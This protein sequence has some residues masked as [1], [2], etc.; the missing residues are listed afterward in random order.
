MGE[1]EHHLKLNLPAGAKS[2]VELVKFNDSNNTKALVAFLCLSEGEETAAIGDMD[3]SLRAVA[4]NVEMALANAL[5]VYYVPSVF[6]PVT[7]M[8]MTTS[9]KLDRKVLRALA[10][11]VGVHVV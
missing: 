3:E 1:I 10:A 2:A 8:P 6:M 5:P 11:V 9:G 4:K 7:R